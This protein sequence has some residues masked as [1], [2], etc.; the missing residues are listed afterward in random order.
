VRIGT[1][2]NWALVSAD[3]TSAAIKTDGSLWA[4][5]L[6]GYG[7]VG[8]GTTTE[9][10]SPVRIGTEN[11]WIFV[12]AGGGHSLALKTDGSL[13]AWGH[14]DYGQLGDGT[15]TDRHSPVRIERK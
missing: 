6:N 8:D 4:W 3:I 13:W 12:S 10:H 11:T 9:R 1:E 15:T 7:Q 14:N 5:G 2:N